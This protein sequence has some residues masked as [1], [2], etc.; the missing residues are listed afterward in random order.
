MP[1]ITSPPNLHAGRPKGSLSGKYLD[2]DGKPLHVWQWRKLNGASYRNNNRKC[3][4]PVNKQ[5]MKLL[6]QFKKDYS[7]KT[8][9][10][11]LL[12]LMDV[13]YSRVFSNG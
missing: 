6:N 8:Y 5:V 12:Y 11:L 4:L 2:E 10:E 3:S 9:Q 13:K 7:F 1:E